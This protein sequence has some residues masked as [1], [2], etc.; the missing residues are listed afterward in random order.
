MPVE[1]HA[2]GSLLPAE[3]TQ[4]LLTWRVFAVGLGVSILV[5]AMY[6]YAYFAQSV[7]EQFR[8]GGDNYQVLATIVADHNP[9]YFD[10]DPVLG[11]PRNYAFYRTAFT[12]LVDWTYQWLGNPGQVYGFLSI[13]INALR[14]LGFFLLGL[15]LF[16]SPRWAVVLALA[17][18]VEIRF[19][20]FREWW[21]IPWVV[22]ART[23]YEAMFPYLLLAAVTANA[24]QWRQTLAMVAAGVATYLHPVSGPP[25][26][27][28]LWA[29]MCSQGG[30]AARSLRLRN[31]L[32][33]GLAYVLVILPFVIHFL[34]ETGF[35]DA[36]FAELNAALR[37]IYHGYMDLPRSLAKQATSFTLAAIFGLGMLGLAAAWRHGERRIVGFLGVF[38][39]ALVFAAIV[40]P[41]ADHAIA[42]ALGRLPLQIDFVRGAKFLAPVAVIGLVWGAKLIWEAGAFPL[43]VV[44]QRTAVIAGGVAF[45][46]LSRGT[47]LTAA[48]IS[49]SARALL[50]SACLSSQARA[51]TTSMY[52]AIEREVPKDNSSL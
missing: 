40:A 16:R 51:D 15:S 12:T 39:A 33:A 1:P 22:Y 7:D 52:R 27:F 48:Q 49:C 26:A 10:A 23:S 11:D 45:V 43:P 47:L 38:S 5:A 31:G 17:S 28:A 25:V 42:A 6:A 41:V 30:G 2:A 9:G 34:A 3:R 13:P 18:A 37:F 19:T 36:T 35:G 44:L 21:G 24:R 14:V 46:A 29:A 20:V 8:Y 50:G 32:A 4:T